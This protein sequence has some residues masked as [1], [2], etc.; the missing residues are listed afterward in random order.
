MPIGFQDWV[1]TSKDLDHPALV[2]H[3][4]FKLPDYQSP[5]MLI[6]D[7]GIFR[8]ISRNGRNQFYA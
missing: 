5:V 2:M 3:V 6:R 8:I 4:S 1:K 7:L